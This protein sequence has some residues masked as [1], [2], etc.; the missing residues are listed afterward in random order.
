MAASVEGGMG[1]DSLLFRRIM[2]R[3]ATGVTVVTGLDG[4]GDPF[5][6]TA[7]SL[8]S[9]SLNPPLISVCV[10]RDAES[11]D[12][13]VGAGAFAV[14]VLSEGQEGIARRF[15]SAQERDSR[16]DGLDW[17]PGPARVPVLAGVHAWM[18]CRIWKTF[19]AGDHTL[20]IARVG[21]GNGSDGRPLLYYRGRYS[22]LDG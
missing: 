6:F 20:V 21:E 5:G 7:N 11:H 9:V 2:G 8:S 10:G 15:A 13:L 1:M 3:F 16:W 19:E 14:N 4:D 18:A 22:R 12:P 17:D